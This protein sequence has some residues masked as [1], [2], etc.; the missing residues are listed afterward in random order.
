MKGEVTSIK[1]EVLPFASVQL[2]ESLEGI[3][4]D[5]NGLFE[6]K[7]LQK[8]QIT[9]I[10]SFTGFLSDT[11]TIFI[12]EST[13]EVTVN[14]QLTEYSETLD[15]I[16]VTGTRTHKR[17]TKNPVIV[18]VINS[19]TL[20]NVQACNLSEGLKFQT[21]L[22]VETDCQTCNYTQLRMNGLSGGYSQ[23]L[24]NGRP[25]FSPLTGLYGLEQVPANMIDR[26][27]VVRGGGSALYGSSAIGGTV[28]VIT[29]IPKRNEYAIGYTY[30]NI[31]GTPDHIIAGNATIVNEEREA[32]VS[33]FINNRSRGL[34]DA[35][36]DRFSELT[37]LKN[38]AFGASIFFLPTNDQKL[39]INFSKLNEYRYGGEIVNK[40]P[41]L[42]LQSE[43]RTHDVY[44]GNVDYQIN[45]NDDRSSFISYFA[46]QYTDREHYTGVFPDD[47]A[48]IQNHLQD[49]PYGI[50]TT[51]TYQ[52]GVQLNHKFE[53]F[54]RGNNVF[55]F[56][57]EFV[58]DG[59]FD[60]IEAYQYTVDQ[61]TKNIGFFFQSDWEV[62]KSIRLLTGIRLDKHNLVDRLISSPRISLLYSPFDKGQIRATFGTG[63]R[64]PQ[65]FDTDLHIAFAGGGVSR[66]TLADN[67]KE[68]RSVSYSMSFNY[69]KPAEHYI[70][71]FTFE[72]FYTRL[73]DAFFLRPTG[74]DALG[75]RFEKRNGDG[76]TVKGI[77]LE[78]R[79]NYDS[80]LQL[81]TGFTFQSSLFDTPVENSDVLP[82]RRIFLRTPN[83]YGYATLSYNP[84]QK[85]S[86]SLN[87]IYTG[88]MEVLH[89]ASAQNL[90]MDTY[91]TS[92]SFTE[93]G[94][95][96]SYTFTGKK[97]RIHF[98]VFGG[99][100]NLFNAYQNDFDIGKERDSNYIYG[101]A[102]PR[103]VFVGI[104]LGSNL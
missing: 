82:A 42:A 48:A 2:K 44:I 20:D 8:G 78:T 57:G 103:T 51:T 49:P 10:A 13:T 37:E 3:H 25:V 43:E 29:K 1:K 99:V 12:S 31:R 65:A 101:P 76:A 4:A 86:T 47:P 92:P 79:F 83:N 88:Q 74:T 81:E 26:I 104:K 39:E 7:T 91:V 71:G 18:N 50:S 63:F 87:L 14:F 59:V 30:Q 54:I 98:Q 94:I 41:H 34:F 58:Q 66:V 68:E 35:N 93:L 19:I 96:S 77:T 6:F 73:D 22:R 72:A 56:G 95:K 9:I 90:P 16:T 15:Q 67:L 75:E 28:N 11:K 102:V 5:A 60:Q 17:R 84:N 61:L 27:E 21:G 45:F 38:T 69:D 46:T 62:N 97:S 85:F 24:I 80:I 32:G 36:N 52:G 64:A 89:M 53:K 55:T 40:A 33:L 70:Y 100:K 23:I